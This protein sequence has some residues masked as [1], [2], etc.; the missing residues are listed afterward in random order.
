MSAEHHH[1]KPHR[2]GPRI[3]A[4]LAR[5]AVMLGLCSSMS[6]ASMKANQAR[7]KVVVESFIWCDPASNLFRS[8]SP[9]MKML[10]HSLEAAAAVT[11]L[12]QAELLRRWEANRQ[13]VTARSTPLHA[14]PLRGNAVLSGALQP[15]QP[16]R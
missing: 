6:A 11:G 10:N 7:A 12:T 9:G 8:E 3:S 14:E 16:A 4:T 1:E 5:P 2:I 13:S 15:H